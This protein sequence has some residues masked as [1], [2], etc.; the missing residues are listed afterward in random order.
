MKQLLYIFL[1]VFSGKFACATVMQ[2]TSCMAQP[3]SNISGGAFVNQVGTVQSSISTRSL[4]PAYSIQDGVR[5]FIRDERMAVEWRASDSTW[6]NVRAI[7]ST[8][9]TMAQAMN[10]FWSKADTVP[11][12]ALMT[13]SA[14]ETAIASIKSKAAS[15]SAM[16]QTGVNGKVNNS[17][18]AN[19]WYPRFGNPV[20]YL[21]AVPAQAFSSLTGKPTTLGGYGI[22]DAYPLSGNPSGF[23]TSVPAQT[24][25]SLTSKPTT[26]AGYGITD[27]LSVPVT[28][29]VTRSIT[30]TTFTISTT[31]I[32]WVNYS[33][34]I[35]CTA[36][37]GSASSGTV[38]LQYSTNAGSTWVDVCQVKNSNTVTLA[39]V[40]NSV[41]IQQAVLSGVIPANAL[42]RMTQ[43]TAGTTAI[44]YVNGQE[45]Y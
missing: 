37:I 20:G 28:N 27:A 22:T 19:R 35:T 11:I 12:N 15:D 24:F 7:D 42:V 1:I 40:L 3:T 36:T 34:A 44:S 43:A 5:V 2:S 39:V 32:A 25:A 16:L 38:S 31:K 29:V 21:T 18:T 10:Q 14:A 45:A 8:K 30:G 13:K 9:I 26:V 17:D 41:T 4:L 33:V 23:L 6:Q